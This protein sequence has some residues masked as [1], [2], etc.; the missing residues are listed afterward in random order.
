MLE[1]IITSSSAISGIRSFGAIVASV[2]VFLGLTIVAGLTLS[3]GSLAWRILGPI[4]LAAS[5]AILISVVPGVNT[6]TRTKPKIIVVAIAVVVALHLAR[7]NVKPEMAWINEIRLYSTPWQILLL[8]TFCVVSPI[9]EEIYF[10]GLLFPIIGL[11]WGLKISAMLT[12]IAFL[13][14]HIS[15]G[16]FLATIILTLLTYFSRSVYPSIAAHIA[17]NTILFVRAMTWQS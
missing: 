10:R 8:F 6:F 1:I 4:A 3:S 7:W 16:V 17:F 15:I 11:H 12:G 5:S 14:L 2:V 13:A 9:L